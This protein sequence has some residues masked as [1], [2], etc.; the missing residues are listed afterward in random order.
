MV[1]C[2]VLENLWLSMGIE[3]WRCFSRVDDA[4]LTFYRVGGASL[5]LSPDTRISLCSLVEPPLPHEVVG[6]QGLNC[7]DLVTRN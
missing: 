3:I 5:S 7:Y 2:G 4:D 6:L 1:C